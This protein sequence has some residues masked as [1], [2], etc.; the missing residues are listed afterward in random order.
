MYRLTPDPSI[1][2]K[3]YL[4]QQDLLNESIEGGLVH[5]HRSTGGDKSQQRDN[6]Y[7]L[8]HPAKF[9]DNTLYTH[10]LILQYYQVIPKYY[11]LYSFKSQSM[12]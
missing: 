9:D 3:R 1:I 6:V 8:I 4:T 5:D 11:L 7:K 12:L 2:H 10:R